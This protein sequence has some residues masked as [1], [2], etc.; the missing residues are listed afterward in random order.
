MPVKLSTKLFKIKNRINTG[1]K[2]DQKEILVFSIKKA[3][4]M[5]LLTTLPL[6]KLKLLL[7]L[8]IVSY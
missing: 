4:I 3:V 5:L 2:Q 8:T 6:L 7:E 1:Q